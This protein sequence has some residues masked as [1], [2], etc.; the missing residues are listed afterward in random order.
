MRFKFSSLALAVSVLAAF[1]SNGATTQWD[2]TGPGNIPDGK[3]DILWKRGTQPDTYVWEMNDVTDNNLNS[4]HATILGYANHADT[5]PPTTASGWYIAGTA[6]FNGDGKQDIL[7]K[8]GGNALGV[9]FMNGPNYLGA[10]GI[11]GTPPAGTG[12]A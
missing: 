4:D 8:S 6:D 5:L 12:P 11:S 1:L 2:L 9:W 3:P 10:A 7:W